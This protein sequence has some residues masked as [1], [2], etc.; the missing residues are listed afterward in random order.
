MTPDL[1]IDIHCTLQLSKNFVT[2]LTIRILSFSEHIVKPYIKS[3][4]KRTQRTT[5]LLPLHFILNLQVCLTLCQCAFN[6]LDIN[7]T[8]A[9]ATDSAAGNDNDNDNDDDNDNDNNNNNNN[10][11]IK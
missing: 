10:N 3:V 1:H 9:T 5:Q 2:S 7:T 4:I 6:G 8:T 11:K